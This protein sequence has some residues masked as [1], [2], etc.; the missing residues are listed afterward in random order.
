MTA[1]VANKPS[2]Q[3]CGR[4]GGRTAGGKRRP[5]SSICQQCHEGKMQ[6]S[7]TVGLTRLTLVMCYQS[8]LT[9]PAKVTVSLTI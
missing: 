6:A 9:G 8:R 3:E 7:S 5:H 2:R 4:L 1:R